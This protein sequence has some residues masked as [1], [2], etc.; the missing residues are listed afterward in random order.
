MAAARRPGAAAGSSTARAVSAGPSPRATAARIGARSTPCS[1]ASAPRVR[2]GRII[3][4]RV[5]IAA[6]RDR[7]GGSIHRIH[8][9]RVCRAT[10]PYTTLGIP[11][12]IPRTSLRP[13]PTAGGGGPA[14]NSATPRAT[15][16]ANSRAPRLLTAVVA[17]MASTPYR[18]ADGDH[19]PRGEGRHPQL[20]E[21]RGRLGGHHRD[22]G[23]RRQHG[24]G[25]RQGQQPRDVAITEAHP[26]RARSP[27]PPPRPG[28][29]PPPR[30]RRSPP[31]GPWAARR[32]PGSDPSTG[33]RP[34]IAPRPPRG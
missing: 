27:R 20:I 5:P 16:P 19:P 32:S 11:A 6:A 10:R 7:P 14:R 31:P 3:T 9:T 22:D 17:A 12:R 8:G 24:R 2:V 4:A 33:A 13:P 26:P 15:G 23:H 34:P 28:R 29:P 1:A 25:R 18:P 30:T 21:G